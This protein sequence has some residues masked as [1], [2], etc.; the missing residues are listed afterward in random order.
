LGLAL[1]YKYET[2]TLDKNVND[3]IALEFKKLYDKGLI[4]QANKLVN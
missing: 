1:N 3:L 4:Y 2:F